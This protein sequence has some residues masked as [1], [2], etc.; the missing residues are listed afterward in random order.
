MPFCAAQIVFSSVR[1]SQTSPVTDTFTFTS[2]GLYRITFALSLHE[3]STP[4]GAE[5]RFGGLIV[6]KNNANVGPSV[7]VDS[8]PANGGASS[9]SLT[10]FFN[11]GQSITLSTSVPFG[12]P[13]FDTAT[14]VEQL[15]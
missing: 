3:S 8:S 5:L 6:D 14:I 1:E 12:S 11:A 9:T 10:F 7:L 13:I 2:A 15:A 4:D